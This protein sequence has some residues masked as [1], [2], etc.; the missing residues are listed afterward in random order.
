[1]AKSS[2]RDL[3]AGVALSAAGL[4]SNA[5]PATAEPGLSPIMAAAQ[6][7]AA[8][9][10]L[11]EGL[12]AA[13]RDDEAHEVSAEQLRISDAIKEGH[14]KTLADAAILLMSAAAE[15]NSDDFYDDG[16]E[17]RE[18]GEVIVRRVM[19]FLA[20]AAGI[21][22]QEYGG[23]WFLPLHD[24]DASVGT[25]A[26]AARRANRVDEAEAQ[27]RRDDYD[28]MLQAL[29][30]RSRYTSEEHQRVQRIVDQVARHWN[31]IPDD[32]PRFD[33]ARRMLAQHGAA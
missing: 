20:A 19:H 30:L 22:L 11:E 25:V 27:R 5:Q 26:E 33:A 3:L 15:I 6:R 10:N 24:A 29:I 1:M 13:D 7:L 21:D 4:A 18:H 17:G 14:P 23:S 9:G 31:N 2:R 8:L 28:T 32:D 12:L 16:T